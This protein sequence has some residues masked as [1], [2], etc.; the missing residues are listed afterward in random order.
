MEESHSLY[1]L[2]ISDQA[3]AAAAYSESLSDS[4]FSPDAGQVQLKIFTTQHAGAPRMLEYPASEAYSRLPT[5]YGGVNRE[6]SP[7]AL[8]ASWKFILRPNWLLFTT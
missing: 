1:Q 3:P 8:W 7:Q 6:S 2:L 4:C 5:A